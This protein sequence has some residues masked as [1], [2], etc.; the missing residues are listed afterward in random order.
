M[1]ALVTGSAGFIGRHMAAELDRRGYTVFGVDVASRRDCLREFA[2]THQW[3]AFFAAGG[4]G[5]PDPA[6]PYDLVVHAAAREPHRA[7][8]DGQPD[9]LIYNQLLDAAMFD[10][11][12]CTRQRHVLYLSSCAADDEKPD[13]YGLLKLTGERMAEQARAAGVPVTAVRPYSG[14]GEDQDERF[15]FGAFIARARRRD[16]P[17]EI[18]GDGTQVRDWIHV[19]DVV[20]G[21]LAAVEADVTGPVSLCTGVGT[22]MLQLV[23]EI[24]AQAGYTPWAQLRPDKPGGVAYRVGDPSRMLQF[25]TPTVDLAEGVKRA[26]AQ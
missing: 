24:C 26:L 4:T 3:Y 15:P 16:D 7:A 5:A 13:A 21:A 2:I 9:S 25:Y 10:W 6:E 11:A 17:F 14:Y 8:I 23:A 18:W 1:R 19:D 20:G 22:S 12:V